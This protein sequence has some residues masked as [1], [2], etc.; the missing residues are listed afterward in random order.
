MP[1]S[2]F[3]TLLNSDRTVCE[4]Q[5][6]VWMCCWS[7]T[8]GKSC[9]VSWFR[10]VTHWNMRSVIFVL[11]TEFVNNKVVPAVYERHDLRAL[12]NVTSFRCCLWS[13]GETVLSIFGKMLD[14][15][16]FLNV[17]IIFTGCC[18]TSFQHTW[19]FRCGDIKIYLINISIQSKHIKPFQFAFVTKGEPN[20]I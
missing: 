6:C 2:V 17:N 14:I 4:M 20:Y 13:T 12:R 15:I 18:R 16:F 1:R 11:F 5:S 19:S 3:G 10:T 9:K 7:G 8:E